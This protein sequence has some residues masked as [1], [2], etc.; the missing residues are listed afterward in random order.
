MMSRSTSFLQCIVASSSCAYR[1]H[2]YGNDPVGVIP[3][4][5]ELRELCRAGGSHTRGQQASC[6]LIIA[7]L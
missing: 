6:R 3:S 2:Y 4:A 1:I 5:A 7:L